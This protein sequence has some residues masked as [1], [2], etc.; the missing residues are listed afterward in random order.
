M[1]NTFE[2]YLKF[3]W[4]GGAKFKLGETPLSF[5]EFLRIKVKDE[6]QNYL[7]IFI[8]PPKYQRSSLFRV[9]TFSRLSL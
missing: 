6:E 2:R 8:P 9:N 7:D 4:Y 5:E 3:T 1:Y